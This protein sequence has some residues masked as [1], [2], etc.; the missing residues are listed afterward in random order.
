[1]WPSGDPRRTAIVIEVAALLRVGG[2][3]E[4]AQA[5]TARADL[6]RDAVLEP[7]LRKLLVD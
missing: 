5:L 2:E 3:D 6:D 7:R 1:V 4:L